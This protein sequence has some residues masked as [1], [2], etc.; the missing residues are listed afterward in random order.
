MGKK[1]HSAEE[2]VSK[3]VRP[4]L[5]VTG[6]R[7]G[8]LGPGFQAG[9]TANPE[10][11]S[12]SDHPHGAGHSMGSLSTHY[13]GGAAVSLGNSLVIQATISSWVFRWFGI[14]MNGPLES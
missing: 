4:H 2:I 7:V 14:G 3:G 5:W 12:H 13:S 1:R 8:G 9:A 11:A 6:L 10:L